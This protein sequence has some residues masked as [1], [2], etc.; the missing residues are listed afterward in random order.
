MWQAADTYGKLPQTHFEE[1][2]HKQNGIRTLS[3][4][5]RAFF[6]GLVPVNSAPI[7]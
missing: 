4:Y 2:S 1:H 3:V 6:R 5:T 7:W